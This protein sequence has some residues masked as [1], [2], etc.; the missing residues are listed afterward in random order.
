MKVKIDVVKQ[1]QEICS[2]IRLAVES[3]WIMDVNADYQSTPL[4][5]GDSREFA[6]FSA[7]LSSMSFDCLVIKIFNLL[8]HS[9]KPDVL[10]LKSFAEALSNHGGHD[11]VVQSIERIRERNKVLKRA[12]ERVRNNGVGHMSLSGS[13][14][15]H[16]LEARLGTKEMREFLQDLICLFSMVSPIC[17]DLIAPP[18]R[19]VQHELRLMLHLAAD[20][21][22]SIVSFRDLT[23]IH[24]LAP[25][26]DEIT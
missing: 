15:D 17:N 8:D 14:A 3:F 9:K 10:S 7:T 1:S 5:K 24:D 20:S 6:A 12:I 18:D 22:R 11:K 4:R 21:R 26:V 13:S 16:L 19:K 23:S 25:V 2:E